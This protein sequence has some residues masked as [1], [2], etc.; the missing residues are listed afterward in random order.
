MQ[1]SEYLYQFLMFDN[2]AFY[3]IHTVSYTKNAYILYSP[4]IAEPL[5]RR[6]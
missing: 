2:I 3:I 6:L 4:L 5:N 1:P